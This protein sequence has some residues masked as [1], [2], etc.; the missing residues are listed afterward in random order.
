MFGYIYITTN[1]LNGMKYVGKRSSS[2]FKP[3]YLGSG[4]RLKA[5]IKYYGKK[6]F[7]VEV[8]EWAETKEDL[9]RLEVEYI[10]KYDAMRSKDFYNIAEG[11]TGGITYLDRR[12]HI[13]PHMQ[14]A[15]ARYA[16]LPEMLKTMTQ[17]EIAIE[18][19]VDQTAIA[20]RIR[21]HNIVV[22]R[23]DEYHAKVQAKRESAA[24]LAHEARR[25][26]GEKTWAGYDLREMYKTM[27]QKQIA[28]V[29]GVSQ[30]RVS[31]RLRQLGITRSG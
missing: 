18:L 21:E 10:T 5:A 2:T 6:S 23:S 30:V 22:E 16:G 9:N 19:G 11:G 12:K 13:D 29:I 14:R 31:Q 24:K 8:V 26:Q 4:L 7:T 27:T 15:A 28:D 17:S 25:A 3:N 1:T 20:Q